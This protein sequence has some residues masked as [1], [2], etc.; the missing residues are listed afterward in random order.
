MSNVI[1]GNIIRIFIVA[2]ELTNTNRALI[3]LP[4][5][6][7]YETIHIEYLSNIRELVPYFTITNNVYHIPPVRS[8]SPSIFNLLVIDTSLN[9]EIRLTVEK[10]GQIP[11]PHYFDKAFEPISLQGADGNEYN[12]IPSDQFK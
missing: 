8:H 5:G 1:I 9:A 2:N 6:Y 12:V 3:T 11:D 10:F 7:S 4:P